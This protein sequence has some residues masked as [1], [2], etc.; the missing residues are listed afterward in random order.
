MD[1][2]MH[3]L[4]IGD[5][6]VVDGSRHVGD[7]AMTESLIEQLSAHADY[8][9][10]VISANPAETAAAYGVAAIPAPGF[11][12]T[13][14]EAERQD[15][16]TAILD[17]ARGYST[18]LPH[19]DPAWHA[20]RATAS[21]DAVVIAGGGNLSS[22]WPDKVAERVMLGRLAE[23]FGKPLF[24]SG[25]TIGPT[26][27]SLHGEQLAHLLN[28]A[29]LVGV[30]ERH[31]LEITRRLGVP[32]DKVRLTIDDAAALGSPSAD[33]LAQWRP[34]SA[35]CLA[36]FAPHT[37]IADREQFIRSVAALLDHAAERTGAEIVLLPHVG[38]VD[39]SVG[40]EGDGA[41]HAE[42]VERMTRPARMLPVLSNRVSAELARGATVSISSRYHPA[43]FAAGGGVPALA[44]SVD[45]YTDVKLEGA[46]DAFGNAAYVFPV[47]SL[48]LGDVVTGFDLLWDG[49]DDHSR[50]GDAATARIQ[51][52]LEWWR[53]LH[54]T[55]M[56]SPSSPASWSEPARR[57]PL[58][59]DLAERVG[60]LRA[61]QASLS[62]RFAAEIIG[63]RDRDADLAAA[64]LRAVQF[65]SEIGQAAAEREAALRRVG[66]IESA[67]HAAHALMAK[68]AEPAF[69]FALRSR[70]DELRALRATK[71]FRWSAAPR[72]AY[73]SVLNRV[74]Q[75]RAAE[76]GR[77]G[78]SRP[79]IE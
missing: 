73:G 79:A 33:E 10:T 21:C 54:A 55:I 24:V 19:A 7:E 4:V 66:E 75:R 20:I 36:T 32:A 8:R 52:N 44:I 76:N 58:L 70:E 28:G 46:L 14:T 31:S 12:A 40:V 37:G 56:R 50:G 16:I 5:V 22:V 67:L 15:R 61:L 35:Y 63:A 3:L 18:A 39:A 65:E 2:S 25:Q 30:R 34:T 45:E 9:F 38:P 17:A 72:R 68:L 69:D 49:R 27:T 48:I 1:L 78:G 59:P 11:A 26:L 29:E 42:I 23:L 47:A 71:T 74:Q 53:E 57:T 51:E 43:V 77:D 64:N 41:L 60:G 62:R 13:D 6:G